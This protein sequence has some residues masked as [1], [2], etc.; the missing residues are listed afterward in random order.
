MCMKENVS[1]ETGKFDG[2][3][4]IEVDID[5]CRVL[6]LFRQAYVLPQHLG[7]LCQDV[8]PPIGGRLPATPPAS[9][10]W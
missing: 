9:M 10:I 7:S 5:L 3:G 8:L 2:C 4:V 1:Y 6:W